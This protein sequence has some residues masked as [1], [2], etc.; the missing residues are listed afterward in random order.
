M[1]ENITKIPE[2]TQNS[3]KNWSLR[4]FY[5]KTAKNCATIDESQLNL[6]SSRKVS[7]FEFGSKLQKFFPITY[8]SIPSH[9]CDK[10]THALPMTDM[11]CVVS[12]YLVPKCH[13]T[14]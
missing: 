7:V 12:C 11:E 2:T 10:G 1:I 14:Y 8:L 9:H 4:V 3:G 13:F 6:S 5:L